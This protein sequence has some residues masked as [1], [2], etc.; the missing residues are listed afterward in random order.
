V[1]L[2]DPTRRERERD[3][4]VTKREGERVCCW[5]IYLEGERHCTSLHE[6]RIDEAIQWKAN[7]MEGKAASAASAARRRRRIVLPFR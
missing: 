7:P 4:K 1:W 6:I 3:L 5:V 2:G